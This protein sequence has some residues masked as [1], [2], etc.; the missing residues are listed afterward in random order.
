MS[1]ENQ[2]NQIAEEESRWE[3]GCW[4]RRPSKTIFSV[5]SLYRWINLWVFEKLSDRGLDTLLMF[6]LLL[7]G[8]GSSFCSLP[9]FSTTSQTFPGPFRDT[10]IEHK[11][12]HCQLPRSRGERL[13][14]VMSSSATEE[15]QLLE[16]G[17]LPAF[18]SQEN[19]PYCISNL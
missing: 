7:L 1:V 14:S 8:L 12:E 3:I 2:A 4:V 16:A 6:W 17:V 13:E 15:I 9:T 18:K 5:S 10:P 11:R 19:E